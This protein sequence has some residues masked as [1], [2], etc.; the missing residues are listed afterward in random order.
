MNAVETKSQLNLPGD[1]K[2]DIESAIKILRTAGCTNIYL[3]GSLANGDHETRSDIDLAVR[4]C[5][6]GRFFQLLGKLLF[7]LKHP[8]DLV[9]LDYQD[10]FSQYLEKEGALVEIG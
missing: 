2:Q 5:P 1:Y 9:N 7:E 3:F 4:G 6:K 8:V 10:A